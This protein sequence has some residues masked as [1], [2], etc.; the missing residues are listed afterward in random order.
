TRAAL[1]EDVLICDAER[2]V[3]IAGIMGGADTEVSNATTRVLLESAYF[4]P[5]R[6]AR[7]ARR[8]NLRSEAS[9]RFERGADPNN[10][11]IAAD[12]AGQLFATLASGR[13]A[14]G[15]VDVYP[16]PLKRRPVRL[17]VARANAL[18]G[19]SLPT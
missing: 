16:K 7:T 10:V 15:A 12:R 6:I 14:R 13:V 19:I 8:L 3:A 5:E 4:A 17:R 2:P 1:K 18:I 11:P 9:V